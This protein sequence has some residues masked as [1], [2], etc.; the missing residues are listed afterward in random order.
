MYIFVLKIHNHVRKSQK[1]DEI[2]ARN[3]T[4]VPGL[5]DPGPGPEMKCRVRVWTRIPLTA[6]HGTSSAHALTHVY[7]LLGSQILSGL[8][9]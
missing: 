2:K 6:L 4:R 1:Y 3:K 8:G 7:D 5:E 9:T